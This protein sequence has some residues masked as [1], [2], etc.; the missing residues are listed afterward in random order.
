MPAASHP[1]VPRATAFSRAA[2]LACLFALAVFLFAP[3]G[4]SADQA[5]EA[6]DLVDKATQTIEDFKADPD[7]T[8]FRD[9][10]PDAKAIMVVPG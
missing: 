5:A 2:A 7:M 3:K 8:W 9:N 4:A 10:L 6:R 1:T